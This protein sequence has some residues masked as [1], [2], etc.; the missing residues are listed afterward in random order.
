MNK[1]RFHVTSSRF[2]TLGLN[3]NNRPDGSGW[4]GINNSSGQF[5]TLS[6]LPDADRS[7]LYWKTCQRPKVLTAFLERTKKFIKLNFLTSNLSGLDSLL[8]NYRN[9]LPSERLFKLSLFR[10]FKRIPFLLIALFLFLMASTVQAQDSLSVY[11]EL[12][13]KNNPGVKAAFNQYLAALEKV[14]QVGSLPDPQGAIEFFL[15]PMELING[16]QVGNIS[17]MQM[18]PWFGT[19]KLTKDEASLMAKAQFELFQEN[20]AGL[21]YNVKTSWY[22]MVKYKQGIKLIDQ[23]IVLL[24]SLEKLTLVK[25]QSPSGSSSGSPSGSGMQVTPSATGNT[26]GMGGMNKQQAG[27]NQPQLGSNMSSASS[28]GMGSKPTGLAD[29]LRVKMEILDQKNQLS[30]LKDQLKTEEANFNS[31][32]NRDQNI[33]IDVPDSLEMETISVSNL[34]VADSILSNNPMLAMFD[35]EGQSYSA[36]AEKARKMGLPMIGVG[37]NYMV[38]QK[39][40]GNM[41]MMNGKDMVMPMLNFTIPIYRKKY[42]AMQNEAKYL[43]ESTLQKSDEMKNM[44]LVQHR[45]LV[46]NFNDATRRVE[47]YR[48]QSDLANRT[49]NLLLA[50]FT[51]EGTDFEEILRVQYKVLEYGLKHIDAVADYNTA[52]ANA[53]KLMN[54][55]K[56]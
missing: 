55:V 13:A 16:N 37:L 30:L 20:K 43:H 9:N 24:E 36:M 21:F 7:R 18:F 35:A 22:Q 45:Q 27:S 56:Y 28:G 31:L 2:F 46:Q 38:I 33:E 32:L 41:S 50:G 12:A 6:G 26:G 49:A 39:Q 53:E 1:I 17:V 10:T 11:M 40:A 54:T 48:E 8:L 25:F 14:P 5:L 42:T 44:L 19:L 15:K 23:N 34:A 29:V 52:V 3:L 4:K 47:L 51:S